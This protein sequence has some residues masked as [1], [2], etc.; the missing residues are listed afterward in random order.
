MDKQE[1]TPLH[2]AAMFGDAILVKTLLQYG[3]R[4]TATNTYECSPIMM[5]LI[6]DG[7]FLMGCGLTIYA[8]D[9]A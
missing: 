6:G 7:T 5:A 3:A 4:A 8:E 2:Y 9:A 1:I